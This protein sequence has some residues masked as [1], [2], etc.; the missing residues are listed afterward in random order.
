MMRSLIKSSLNLRFLIVIIAVAITF[1]GIYR[2]SQ[3]PVDILPEFSQPYVEIQTESLG[4]SAVEVEQLITVP[5]EQDLLNGT[6][7]VDTIRSESIP[8]LSSIVITFKPGTDLMKARQMV[9]ERMTQAV[10]LPHV[11]KPPTILQPLSSTGRVMIVGL[12]SKN[13]SLLQLG[14][15]V[16]WTIAPRLMGVPG[17]ASVAVWGQR[18]RQLQVLIDPIRMQA[19][20]VTIDSVLETTGNA[21]WVSSLSFVEASTPGTGGFIESPNQR[22]GVFHLSPIVTAE[23]LAQVPISDAKQADGT[24]L[25]LADI[26]NVIEDN[27]PLIGNAVVNGNPGLLL[28]IEKFPGSNTREVTRGLEEALAQMQPGLPNVTIDTSL[29]RPAAFIE[30]SLGNL[31]LALL[32]G[33][34]LLVVLLGIFY[35]DWRLA[36][37]S[38]VAIIASLGAAGFALSMSGAT[39]NI[40][41]LAGLMMAIGIL[42]DDT[43]TDLENIMG[44]LRQQREAGSNPSIT[45]IIIDTVGEMRGTIFFALLILLIAVSPIFFIQGSAGAFF[46]PLALS[47]VIALLTSMLVALTVT[48]SMYFILLANASLTKRNSPVVTWL[49]AVYSRALAWTI[50]RR[51]LAFSTFGVL[52]LAGL[53]VLPFQNLVLIPP[54]QERDLLIDLTSMP[55][56]SQPE[57]TRMATRVSDELRTVPGVRNIGDLIGRAVLGDQMVNVN[58]AQISVSID[59]AA[60]YGKTVTAIQAIVNAYPGLKASVNSYLKEASRNVLVQSNNTI[61]VRVYGDVDSVLQSSAEAVQ[62]AIT[63]IAGIT[64]THIQ[65]P[66]QELNVETE[67]N[68]SKAQI[69]GLKPGD[70]RRAAATMLSGIQVGSLF[71]DQKVFDVVVWSTPDTRHSLGSIQNL[72]IDTPAGGKVRLGDVADVRVVPADTVIRH[73][74]AKRYQDVIVIVHGKSLASVA[75]QINSRIQ[76]ITYPLEYHA[77]VI[78]DYGVQQASLIRLLTFS[79]VVLIGIIFLLQAAFGSWRLAILSI[80][81]LPSA[82]AGGVLTTFAS[83]GVISIGSIVGFLAVFGIT[84]RNGILL[85][86]HLQKLQRDEHESLNLALVIRGARERFSPI[87]MTNL[88]IALVLLPAIIMGDIP[89]LEIIHPMAIFIFGGLITSTALNLFI[90]P[91][92]YLVIRVRPAE[93]FVLASVTPTLLTEGP[94]LVPVSPALVSEKPIL[95]PVAPSLTSSMADH[96]SET[97]PEMSVSEE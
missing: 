28:V 34:F 44:R 8:G 87:A 10:A 90:L 39:I 40:M 48:P 47:Y 35:W 68:L 72:L 82:L 79:I 23:G 94:E 92:L 17:V 32:I 24:P 63:G 97:T 84:A 70:V 27:Q 13:L 38:I 80:L 52:V 29:Y 57:M 45:S 26:A 73:E 4:L 41:A 86:N 61:I 60:D 6:P 12:S 5:M 25:R 71:E 65:L 18:D 22:L 2:L 88:A 67:V 66:T 20:K 1:I 91:A 36:L 31:G 7:W 11:S 93:E 81:A 43:V 85:I 75:N 69:Y 42:I 21:L 15:L 3:M 78:G 56:T 51:R 59:P 64:S 76:S 53:I 9:S 77:A 74:A 95:E 96:L 58:S 49:Q 14:V 55:G 37:I 33:G 83:G 50:Q 46:R 62:K 19:Q 54:F 30:S 89:G 16:R